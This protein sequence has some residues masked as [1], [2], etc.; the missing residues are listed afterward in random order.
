MN[1]L[2]E[3]DR[4]VFELIRLESVRLGFLPDILLFTND[5][6]GYNK[7]KLQIQKDKYLIEVFGVGSSESRDEK[8]HTKIVIDRTGNPFGSIGSFG[9]TG[10][11]K[12]DKGK[13]KKFKYPSMT[14]D[15]HYDVRIITNSTAKERVCQMLLLRC[16]GVNKFIES[17]ETKD[18]Y[19]IIRDG[20]FN[21]SAARLLEYS[22][23]YIIKDIYL[24]ECEILGEGIPQLTEVNMNQV[25]VTQ[26]AIDIIENN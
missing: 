11:E 21:L 8:I 1:K 15:L 22:L 13:F 19:H 14:M 18:T 26:T 3:I 4:T 24:E 12:D 23:K 7:A 6:E 20:F 9:V 10:F 5:P 2:E 25:V 16:L 17:I